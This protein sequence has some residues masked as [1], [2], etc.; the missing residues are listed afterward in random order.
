MVPPFVFVIRQLG[1]AT[2][3]VRKQT[4]LIK[5]T[6]THTHAS[7][8][9]QTVRWRCVRQKCRVCVCVLVACVVMIRSCVSDLRMAAGIRNTN[10]YLHNLNLIA[11]RFRTELVVSFGCPPIL[12]TTTQF[13]RSVNRFTIHVNL[14]VNIF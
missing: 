10:Q 2:Q 4:T 9:M 13:A 5:H 8:F 1:R 12:R 11:I 7:I 3:S 6:H 14:F